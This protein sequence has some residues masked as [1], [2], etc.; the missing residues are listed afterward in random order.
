MGETNGAGTP[1]QKGNGENDDDDTPD[2]PP[3]GWWDTFE[4]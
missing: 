3:P 2:P 1:G 4:K